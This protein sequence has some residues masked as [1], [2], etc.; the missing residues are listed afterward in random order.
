MTLELFTSEQEH[1]AYLSLGPLEV[2]ADWQRRGQGTYGWEFVR[3]RGGSTIYAGQVKIA[4]TWGAQPRATA[5]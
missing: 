3:E 5:T 2:W 1:A 4:W